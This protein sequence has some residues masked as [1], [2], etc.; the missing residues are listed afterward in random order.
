METLLGLLF[1][2]LPFILKLI[3]KKLEKA[4]QP[5]TAAKMKEIAKTVVPEDDTFEDFRK[6]LQSEPTVV[7]QPEEELAAPVVQQLSPV[8]EENVTRQVSTPV[9]PAKKPILEEEPEKKREKIDPKKLVVYS[10][11]MKPKYTE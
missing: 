8:V 11:I 6:W 3:G 1:I 5:E 9:K 7:E 10:E 4:G 2:L